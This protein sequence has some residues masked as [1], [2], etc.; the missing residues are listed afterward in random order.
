MDKGKG[1][2]LIDI[3]TFLPNESLLD[4][5]LEKF[6]EYTERDVDKVSLRDDIMPLAI[7]YQT[8]KLFGLLGDL[9]TK[10]PFNS[11]TGEQL[12]EIIQYSMDY[13]NHRLDKEG[14]GY[15]II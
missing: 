6:F 9:F 15:D 10:E 7:G 2:T 8:V 1:I 13:F 5:L 4:N 11:L 14:Y 12:S 3:A